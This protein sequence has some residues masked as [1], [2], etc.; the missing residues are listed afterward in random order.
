MIGLSLFLGMLALLVVLVQNRR[1]KYIDD[2]TAI[3]PLPVFGTICRQTRHST[4]DEILPGMW[5]IYQSMEEWLDKPGRQIVVVSPD[6][7]DGKS[8]FSTALAMEFVKADRLVTLVD[9]NIHRPSLSKIF[10]GRPIAKNLKLIGTSS[11]SGQNLLDT[12]EFRVLLEDRRLVSDVVLYDASATADNADCLSL[13]GPNS[14]VI[15]IVRLGHTM[16]QSLEFLAAQLSH[17]EIADG[18]LVIFGDA[19][20]AP[21][22]G[23][24]MASPI[25]TA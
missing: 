24:P 19:Q 10:S 2:V 1:I 25:Y 8:I 12:A 18:A 11:T 3:I 7:G 17:K 22:A 14:Y 23:M 13:L 16:V 15:V 4:E 5:R 9:A 21:E 20:S 6:A